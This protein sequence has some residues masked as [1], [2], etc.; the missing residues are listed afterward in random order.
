MTNNRKVRTVSDGLNQLVA[1]PGWNTKNDKL[2][3]VAEKMVGPNGFVRVRYWRGLDMVS[4]VG[5]SV[6]D[7]AMTF[8]CDSFINL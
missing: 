1:L 8:D 2:R 6:A 4:D 3:A 5:F 7:C